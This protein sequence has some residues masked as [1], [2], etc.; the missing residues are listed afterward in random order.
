MLPPFVEVLTLLGFINGIEPVFFGWGFTPWTRTMIPFVSENHKPVAHAASKICSLVAVI[1]GG[2]RGRPGRYTTGG[3][4]CWIRLA[5]CRRSGGV[6]QKTTN[7]LMMETAVVVGVGAGDR[8]PGGKF[9]ASN[10]WY[11]RF[12]LGYQGRRSR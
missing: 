1:M 5:D 9:L 8:R 7:C 6:S 11:Q 12:R 10:R 2:S 3:H 4:P